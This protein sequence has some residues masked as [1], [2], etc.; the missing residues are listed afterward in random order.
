MK[1]IN[2]IIF[3]ALSMIAVTAS[4]VDSTTWVYNRLNG[5]GCTRK[6]TT[7]QSIAMRI[8]AGAGETYAVEDNGDITFTS[9]GTHVDA[10][11]GLSGVIDVSAAA[12]DTFGEVA[13]AINASGRAKCIL[14][15]VLPS[16]SSNNVMT[17]I[18]A[19][20]TGLVTPAGASITYNTADLDRI[21]CSI[22]PEYATDAFIN[23][24]ADDLIQKRSN[25]TPTP[26][27]NEL[28]YVKANSTFS[29]GAMKLKVYAV[30]DDTAN[31]TEMELVP[32]KTG[33]AT[34]VDLEEDLLTLGTYG[35]DP[36]S[37][38]PFAYTAPPG[39]RIVVV[40]ENVTTGSGVAMT[41][42]SLQV[43]GFSQHY[44]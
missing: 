34:T 24:P 22:G 27:K 17:A 38:L 35:A 3:A 28:F 8:T 10:S 1:R 4:A 7:D 37:G 30:K 39:W 9:D 23:V 19:T 21:S 33:A 5:I 26:W 6:V 44:R 14:V 15:D 20:S 18:A 11:I 2:M 40:Y 12:Y 13:A 43:H 41:T 29:A 32:A 36:S 42:G 16:W 25:I 31:A